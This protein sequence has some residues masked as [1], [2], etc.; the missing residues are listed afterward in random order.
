[1]R[2]VR[3]DAPGA[4]LR[5]VELPLPEPAGTEVRIRVAAC[6]V[7]RTDLHIVDGSQPRVE[8]PLTLG[9]E[10]AGW[11]DAIGPDAAKAA[12]RARLKLGDPVLVFGGWGCGQCADCSAGAEQRCAR[13]RAPGFQA[14]GGYAEAMLVPDSR[15]LL[16]LGKLDPARAAPLA[17]A[18]VTPFRAVRR[19]W[20]WLQPGAR[21]LLIGCGGLG[22][23]AL[24]YVRLQH[25]G[26]D[27]HIAVREIDAG[28]LE[29]A[30]ELGADVGIL[31]GDRAMTIEALGGAPA[32][33]VL[34]FVGSDDTL[35]LA[36]D[37]V[38]PGGLVELVGEGAGSL[39][40]GFDSPPIESWLTTVAWGGPDDLRQVVE[41]ARRGRLRWDVESVAL[42]EASV[43]HERLR[44]NE[45]SGRLV[46]V[47]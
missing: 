6:G 17:D 34:D 32:D 7:C 36:A 20:P 1:M 46:L 14:D 41:L 33:V 24:Q 30:A 3:L 15:Y 43:A 31:E 12:R 2:A 5:L 44:A 4:Q 19:A 26:K 25:A 27:I 22:Q 18:G 47:P 28:R 37:V 10:V 29:R 16:P 45:V 42:E 39:R 23:F 11:I 38:A 40:F 9:H 21:V 13:S 8:L 35:A